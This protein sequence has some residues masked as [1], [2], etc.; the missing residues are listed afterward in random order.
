MNVEQAIARLF[1]KTP[2]VARAIGPQQ[3]KETI[4]YLKTEI[5]GIKQ[6]V[7]ARRIMIR[8]AKADGKSVGHMEK[9]NARA[10]KELAAFEARLVDFE[11]RREAAKE[12]APNPGRPPKTRVAV[13][14]TPQTVTRGPRRVAASR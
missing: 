14:P 3:I 6:L 5:A 8:K 4:L 12:L 10:A 11:R 9:A 13:A 7:A 1:Q 2:V